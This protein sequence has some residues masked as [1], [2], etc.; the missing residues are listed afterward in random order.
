M[1]GLAALIAAGGR[2]V[3]LD[4]HD[5]T[6]PYHLVIDGIRASAGPQDC[7]TPLPAWCI[8]GGPGHPDH[9]RRPPS[10]VAA[11]TALLRGGGAS[12]PDCHVRR[13]KPCHLR[14]LAEPLRRSR[15]SISDS[16]WIMTR[17]PTWWAWMRTAW[18]RRGVSERA[19]RQV[20]ARGS[21]RRHRSDQYPC[22]A[23]MSVYARFTVA[24]VTS[25]SSAP[26]DRPPPSRRSCRT[27]CFRPG[28]S[29]RIFSLR[30]GDRADGA[31]VSRRCRA[32]AARSRRRRWAQ[33]SAETHSCRLA[34]D[35]PC[36]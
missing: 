33:I 29:R 22:A 18:Q 9:R 35:P 13:G 7:R 31:E 12:D 5:P 4:D 11:D 19:Q 24:R 27:W 2:L 28:G 8:R 16:A 36:G 3:D 6:V 17:Q 26:K 23:V 14:N 25:D 10:G 21:R 34:A 15:W 30:W 20:R 32:R 1:A